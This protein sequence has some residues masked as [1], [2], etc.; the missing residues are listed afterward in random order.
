MNA[1]ERLLNRLLSLD[2]ETA[3]DLAG[4]SGKVIQ[5]ELLNTGQ[6]V[7]SLIVNEHAIRVDT[8]YAGTGDVLIRGTPLDL[9]VY[10][11][12]SAGDRQTVTGNMEIRGDLGLAQ[13][14]Q[15]LLRSFEVDWEEQAAR[16][17]GDT[18][19]RK[20]SNIVAM[21]A[22]FL[23]HLKSKIEM[24]LSEYALY[25]TEVLPERDEIEHFNHSVD[26]LRDDLERLKQRFHRLSA[27]DA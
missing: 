4:L 18:L 23:Q 11:R 13:D 21:G 5:L 2:G 20:A 8:D 14:F 12:S 22:D 10:M 17:V 9:L 19:A 3:D 7:I 6:P 27:D 25:E 26:T 1:L 15:R 24:D 16:L